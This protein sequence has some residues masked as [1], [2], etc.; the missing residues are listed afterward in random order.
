M[1][2]IKTA[3]IGTGAYA[4]E[5]VLTNK[6][7]EKLVETSDEWI[8]ERTG[9]RERHVAAEGEATSDMALK[10]AVRAL[11]MASTRPEEL[12]LVIVGTVT[13][14]M[15][16]PACAAFLQA[17]LGAKNAMAFDVSAACAGSIFGL[18][19]GDMYV[20]AGTAKRVLVIGAELLTSIVDWQDRNTC[21]LFGDAAGA[22]VLGPSP[23][24]ARG[25]LGHHLRTEGSLTDILCIRGGG[26]KLPLN[27]ERLQQKLNKV[28]MNGR[29]VYKFAVRALTESCKAV[30]EANGLAPSQ[31]T[32]VIAHQ[33]NIRIIDAI[34]ERLEV[35][36]EKCWLNIDRYGNTSSASLPTTLDEANRAGRLKKGDLVLM[37]A[38]GAGMAYGSS[39]VRW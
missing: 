6:D 18:S 23:D 7:L 2:A 31:V 13:P 39:V 3:I 30:L 36:R 17:K 29:E 1:T 12:D 37:M 22:M 27:Q 35:P 33:A 24:P 11:E 8:V 9:I 20:R 38:I 5:K 32:H 14:D 26:S 19:I 15:P 25:I 28:S 4:P 21:V 10:A 16:M 34:L